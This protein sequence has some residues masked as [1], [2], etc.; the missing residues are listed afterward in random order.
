[1][2][3]PD[4]LIDLRPQHLVWLPLKGLQAQ[5]LLVLVVALEASAGLAE[6]EVV[7]V[8][9]LLLPLVAGEGQGRLVRGGDVAVGDVHVDGA[10]LRVAG[11][12]GGVVE[13]GVFF[14]SRLNRGILT[15]TLYHFHLILFSNN[16]FVLQ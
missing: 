9:L 7:P 12:E 10:E 5:V 3:L 14:V 1:M 2:L 8:A 16:L 15:C 13:T 6:G 11:T 4:D